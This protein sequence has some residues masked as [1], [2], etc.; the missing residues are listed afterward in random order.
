MGPCTVL[1]WF[2]FKAEALQVPYV[3]LYWETIIQKKGTLLHGGMP[4]F[5]FSSEI[6]LSKLGTFL[7]TETIESEIEK[8]FKI[9]D[10][11]PN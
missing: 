5:L 7:H 3:K 8:K 11:A 10:S 1:L 4:I 6:T 9:F 2:F